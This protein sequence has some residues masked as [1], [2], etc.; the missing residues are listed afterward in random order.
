MCLLTP[1]AVSA[2]FLPIRYVTSIPQSSS[3]RSTKSSPGTSSV[4]VN[5]IVA[6]NVFSSLDLYV[7]KT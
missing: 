6:V 2:G 1:S 7:I 5:P 4:P 3:P